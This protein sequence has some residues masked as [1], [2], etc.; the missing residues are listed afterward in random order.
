M[1]DINCAIGFIG[2][3][4]MAGALMGTML[5][6]GV[7][8]KE[9]IICSDVN[10]SELRAAQDKLGVRVTSD[11]G[12]VFSQSDIVFLAIKPQNFPQAVQGLAHV[13]HPSHI[14]VS[15][16]AGIRI[17]QIGKVLPRAGPARVLSVHK[18][19]CGV[20]KE[21]AS[22]AVPLPG[23]SASGAGKK[24]GKKAPWKNLTPKVH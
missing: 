4:K 1:S 19:G 17:E 2:A 15:I 20:R 10:E 12:E 22:G 11:N 5:H 16:M 9:N 6:S 8:E 21:S 23:S 24:G 18:T 14:I 13:V 7:V 3:G